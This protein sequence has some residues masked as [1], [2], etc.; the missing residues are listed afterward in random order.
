MGRK[1][2]GG[3][4]GGGKLR[5][6]GSVVGSV[7]PS[8]TEPVVVKFGREGIEGPDMTRCGIG[9]RVNAERGGKW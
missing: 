3:V 6:V 1:C 4:T 7:V 9:K 8:V 2:C 5:E